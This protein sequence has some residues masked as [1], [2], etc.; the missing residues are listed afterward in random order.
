MTDLK[1]GWKTLTGTP[2]GDV[3]D[4]VREQSRDGQISGPTRSSSRATRASSPS[5]RS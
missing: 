2:I 5:S 1:P 3:V 4:F